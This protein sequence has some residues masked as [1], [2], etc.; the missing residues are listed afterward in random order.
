MSE[1]ELKLLQ[2]CEYWFSIKN[3]TPP[4]EYISK[5]TGITKYKIKKI[6]N[7]LKNMGYID[8]YTYPALGKFDIILK[9]PATKTYH[10]V[11]Y[12]NR[13]FSPIR[14]EADFKLKLQIVDPTTFQ[15]SEIT[16]K[17][18]DGKL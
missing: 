17:A 8:I 5:E 9:T 4:I 2:W 16:S 10:A 18:I 6:L 1:D 11:L 3:Y 12:V 13:E 7:V 14:L 15:I